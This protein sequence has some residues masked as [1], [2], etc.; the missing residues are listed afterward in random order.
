[1]QLLLALV[2]LATGSMKLLRPKEQLASSMK[3]VGHVSPQTV[4]AIGAVEILGAVG[5]ILPA[6]TGILPW[7]TPL[8]AIG[9]ALTMVGAIITHMRLGEAAKAIAPLVLL[10]LL[11][12]VAYGRI[13]LVPL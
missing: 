7:L 9:L 10:L 13:I 8:A 11:M 4:K 6:L 12:V 2:F 3:W 5:L 1:M